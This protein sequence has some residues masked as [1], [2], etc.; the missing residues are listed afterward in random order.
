MI[1]SRV[2]LPQ[3]EGPSRLKNDP[4]GRSRLTSSTATVVRKRLVT[5]RTASAPPGATGP[6]D[7]A[8]TSL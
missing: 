4:E 3:P 7:P 6:A 2:V 5:S 8:V 1:R